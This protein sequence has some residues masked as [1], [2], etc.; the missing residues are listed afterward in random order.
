METF[1]DSLK[2]FTPDKFEFQDLTE[3]IKDFEDFDRYSPNFYYKLY[4]E[5]IKD[6]KIIKRLHKNNTPKHDTFS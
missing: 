2:Y 6:Y 5:R 3:Y 1:L 4:L